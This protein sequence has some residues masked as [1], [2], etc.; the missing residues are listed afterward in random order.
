VDV[1]HKKRG[2]P[3]LRDEE[4]GRGVT[5]GG[6]NSLAHLY[7]AQSDLSMVQGSDPRAQTR[8][9]SYR[10]IRSQ[11]ES[12]YGVSQ[13]QFINPSNPNHPSYQD[14]L[15]SNHSIPQ[16][17][18]IALLTLDFV[19]LRSNYAFSEAL[20]LGY[21]FQNRPLRD[22]L[23]TSDRDK[24][25]RLQ[26]SLRTELQDSAHLPPIRPTI[27]GGVFDV[28]SST[29]G[30]QQRSEYWTF[31][32]PNGQSRGFP[33]SVSL[34]RTTTYFLV[35]TLV[36]HTKPTLTTI[37][38]ISHSGWNPPVTSLSSFSRQKAIPYQ[39]GAQLPSSGPDL[40]PYRRLSSSS[41]TGSGYSPTNGSVSTH[42]AR[43]SLQSPEM[44]RASLKLPPIR[45]SGIAESPRRDADHSKGGSVK[46]SPQSAKRMKRRRVEIGEICGK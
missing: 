20:S 36:A 39:S 7:P 29:S 31:Q 6:E 37:L 45:T 19:V 16:T 46:G 28:L 10:E 17:S 33:V 44:A 11:P 5:F 13:P 8:N 38:P 42:T 26:Y 24:L 41:Q 27:P 12:L 23:I 1:Q 2:R 3:R 4:Q 35:L 14:A 15:P 32:L 43:S 40:A 22:L 9:L 21:N 34:A 18:P 25:Q 30:F